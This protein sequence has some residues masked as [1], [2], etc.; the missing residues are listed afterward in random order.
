MLV[1]R[2]LLVVQQALDRGRTVV[3]PA[4]GIGTGLSR[5]L[6]GIPKRLRKSLTL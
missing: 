2:D 4:D 6:L 1:E 3:V 5:L